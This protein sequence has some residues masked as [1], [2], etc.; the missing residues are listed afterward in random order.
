[1]YMY[2]GW[3]GKKELSIVESYSFSHRSWS[4]LHDL[5]QPRPE[6]AAVVYPPST[7]TAAA[8]SRYGNDSSGIQ[9]QRIYVFGGGLPQLESALT[10]AEVF[11]TVSYSWTRIAGFVFLFCPSFPPLLKPEMISGR[12]D[13]TN[14]NNNRYATSTSI[15]SRHSI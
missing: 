2:L 11:D 4:T 13:M 1:M 10:T 14:N 12:V 7:M 15:T 8:R 6:A 3:N 5:T 9:R